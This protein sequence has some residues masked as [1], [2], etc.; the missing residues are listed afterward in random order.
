MESDRSSRIAQLASR[1]ASLTDSQIRWIE[2]IAA[3]FASNRRFKLLE[4]SLLS[5]CIANAFGD[6]LLIHHCFSWQ[7]LTKDKFEYVLENVSNYCGVTAAL[8]PKALR[9][10]DITIAGERFS[11]KT[12]A[13]KTIREDQIYISKF[14]ELGKGQWGD[15]PADLAGLRDQFLKHLDLYDRVLCLRAL[16]LP[17]L[18]W[19][20]ELVEVPLVLLREAAGGTLEMRLD[21]K[22]Y[23]KPGYC[24]VKDNAGNDKFQLYFDGGTERKLQLKHLRKSL[25][26]VHATW[27]FPAVQLYP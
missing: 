15:N 25:C 2:A 8:A 4:S 14:M 17:P 24:H 18:D 23:P 10:P 1:L 20:Y 6:A 9:G 13:D 7:P 11:L 21:S 22:Q 5:E 16:T 26:R 27:Q 3:Q 19:K 12:Q